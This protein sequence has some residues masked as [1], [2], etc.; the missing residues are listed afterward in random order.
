MELTMAVAA[1]PG[2]MHLHRTALALAEG[3]VFVGHAVI[4]SVCS[5]AENATPPRPAAPPRP[6]SG[7]KNAQTNRRIMRHGRKP[8]RERRSAEADRTQQTARQR[9]HA[10]F[11]PQAPR[12]GPKAVKKRSAPASVVQYESSTG[13]SAAKF[14]TGCRYDHRCG[15][16]QPTP[17]WQCGFSCV[18]R[19]YVRY[20][21]VPS[22][23]PRPK[24]PA[25]TG[26]PPCVGGSAGAGCPR[27]RALHH[28]KKTA[29][30]PAFGQPK[31]FVPVRGNG[32]AP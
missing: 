17:R 4:S 11:K 24:L 18:Y 25:T 10:C 27:T 7:K 6:V 3:D 19:S 2:D 13:Q 8:G 32:P 16:R 20:I 22:V 26:C 14:G 31:C 1:A 29:D 5:F 30:R 12:S 23:G 21:A 15:P 28:R 9:S